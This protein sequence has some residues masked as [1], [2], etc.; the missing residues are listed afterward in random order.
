M[1]STSRLNYCNYLCFLTVF[2]FFFHENLIPQTKIGYGVSSTQRAVVHIKRPMSLSAFNPP[3][4]VFK[5]PK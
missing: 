4:R 3:L 2:F 5:Y 1:L